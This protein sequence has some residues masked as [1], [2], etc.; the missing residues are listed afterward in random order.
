MSGQQKSIWPVEEGEFEDWG[1]FFNKFYAKFP[2]RTIQTNHIFEVCADKPTVM[3]VC[4]AD[5]EEWTEIPMTK[6]SDTQS[7]QEH[8][9]AMKLYIRTI[10]PSPSLKDI[11][12][13]EMQKYV[14]LVGD[15]VSDD[16]YKP[17][18]PEVVKKIKAEKEAKRK[19]SVEK[20][21]AAKIAKTK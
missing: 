9:A 13:V 12:K 15:C 8:V 17:L 19:A 16:L 4:V 6:K 7:K 21:K 11:K 14:H 5:G 18:S 1:E 10:I 2:T 20:K 3:K